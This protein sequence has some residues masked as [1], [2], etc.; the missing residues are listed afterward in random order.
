MEQKDLR[1]Q[2]ST[3]GSGEWLRYTVYIQTLV[4]VSQ[5]DLRYPAVKP[6]LVIISI[7]Q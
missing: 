4:Y 2:K 3:A 5:R 1:S 6:A 7:K